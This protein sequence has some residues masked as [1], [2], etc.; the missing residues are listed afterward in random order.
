VTT[1]GEYD[2][3][4]YEGGGTH[5]GKWTLP[6][7]QQQFAGLAAAMRGGKP[8]PADDETPRDLTGK[9]L[10]FQTGVVFDDK[11]LFK[12]FGSVNTDAKP[13]YTK[14]ETAVVEFWTSHPKNDLHRNGTFL[15][16]QRQVNGQWVTVA[17]LPLVTVRDRELARDDLLDDPGGHPG[18]HVP[19]RPLRR[20]QGRVDGPDP[21]VHRYVAHVHRQ[22]RRPATKGA[23]TG[24]RQFTLPRPGCGHLVLPGTAHHRPAPATR[25][26]RCRRVLRAPCRC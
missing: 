10:N 21:S 13:S 4:N 17:D 6:V 3:Q 24:A 22:L 1:P 23:A 5:F 8:A 20:L 19:D 2:T 12:S 25:R 15:E 18:R 7:Y 14:G 11:P 26:D 16:V 9:Q